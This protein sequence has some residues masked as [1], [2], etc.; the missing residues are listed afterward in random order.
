MLK[1]VIMLCL[2][3]LSVA[4]TSCGGGG[5]SS[6]GSGK[7]ETYDGNGISFQYPKEFRTSKSITSTNP[8]ASNKLWETA[9]GLNA[10]DGVFLTGYKL[11][12]AITPGNF[13]QNYRQL[14]EETVGGTPKTA[15]VTAPPVA[16]KV[17]GLPAFQF[18]VEGELRPGVSTRN[19]A[20]SVYAGTTQVIISCQI[21][22]EKNAEA[23][24]AACDSVLATLKVK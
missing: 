13:E 5:D 12:I 18:G 17:G 3:V 24:D 6:G 9:I 21:R 15:K 16:L 23:V 10:D 2:G 8:G 4:L 20:T 11:K 1:L 7:L 14:A 19:R 22:G